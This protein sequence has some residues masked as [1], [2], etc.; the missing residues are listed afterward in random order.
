MAMTLH[1]QVAALNRIQFWPLCPPPPVQPV[2]IF[3]KLL[4]QIFWTNGAINGANPKLFK[5]CSLTLLFECMFRLLCLEVIPKLTILGQ[6][7][8]P[9]KKVNLN[10]FIKKTIA[11]FSQ[12]FL[13]G[14]L[15]KNRQLTA[16]LLPSWLP[17]FLGL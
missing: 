2:Y 16:F 5:F 12:F 17:V 8:N 13:V 10:L 1:K 4:L 3:F 15:P 11:L 6:S 7:I 14:G 9:S